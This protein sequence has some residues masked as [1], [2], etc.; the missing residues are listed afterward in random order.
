[1][2]IDIDM[3][4]NN[5]YRT[6]DEILKAYTRVK[7]I[8]CVCLDQ[9]KLKLRPGCKFSKNQ[10]PWVFL[11]LRLGSSAAEDHKLWKKKSYLYIKN[12]ENYLYCQI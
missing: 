10:P 3:S 8:I 11:S 9:I 12:L 6:R 4:W 1:M 5:C 7:P 2:E